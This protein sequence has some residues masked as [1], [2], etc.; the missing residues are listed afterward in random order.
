[1]AL[2]QKAMETYDTL[3]KMG[4]VGVYE[5]GKTPLAPIWHNITKADIEI[6]IDVSGEFIEANTL[7]KNNIINKSG[8]AIIPVTAESAVRTGNDNKPHPLCDNVKYVIPSAADS[9]YHQ[10]YKKLLR[11]WKESRY[12]HPIVEAVYAYIEKGTIE[13]DIEHCIK[14]NKNTN[15]IT[16]TGDLIVWRILGI[17]YG[18]CWKNLE[19]FLLHIRFSEYKGL[20]FGKNFCIAL[21]NQQYCLRLH[22]RK[23]VPKYVNAKLIS[24]NDDKNF[25]YLGRFSSADEA[26]TVSA[27]ASLKAHN[28]LRYLTANNKANQIGNLSR[29]F[30][31]WCPQGEKIPQPTRPGLKNSEPILTFQNYSAELKKKLLSYKSGFDFSS[32]AVVLALDVTTTK[33]PGRLSVTYYNELHASDFAERI[34]YWDETC[35]WWRCKKEQQNIKYEILAPSLPKI[36]K[37][38]FG[39]YRKDDDEFEADDRVL[40]QHLQRLLVCRIDKAIFPYDILKALFVRCECL[41]LYS[42]KTREDLLFVTCAAIRKY[43]IDHKK[44]EIQLSLDPEK[45]DRSYQYGRLLALME[46]AERDTYDK[47]EGREPNAMRLLPVFTQRPLYATKIIIEQLK[48]AYFPKLE[49]GLRI[50]YDNLIGEIF[51]ILDSLNSPEHDASLNEQY[52]IGYYL[53]RQA[54]YTPKDQNKEEE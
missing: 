14:R 7:S 15:A 40:A 41:H 35:S 26:L 22:P 6:T 51:I 48:K 18:S 19:L 39:T 53:Q 42:I 38:A 21:G 52:L 45:K 10:E 8:G 3:D 28:A 13:N 43:Y 37:Y 12:T 25:T 1:M 5:A 4:L 20:K 2:M 34:F 23:I 29:S 11:E 33:N 9:K 16:N 30:L 36:A 50:W 46:K 54:L 49:P 32:I 24:S 27:N 31:S 17:T 47:E 44:E